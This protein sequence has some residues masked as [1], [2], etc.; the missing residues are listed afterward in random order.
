MAIPTIMPRC[1]GWSFATNLAAIGAAITP[2]SA[3]PPTVDQSSSILLKFTKKPKLAA[4]ATQNSEALTVPITFLGSVEVV[5]MIVGVTTG[6]Q[7]PPPD[8]SMKPPEKPR[9]LKNFGL[10]TSIK[11]GGF[12]DLNIFLYRSTKPSIKRI[13]DMKTLEFDKSI[14]ERKFAPIK[15]PIEPGIA[16]LIMI[17][18]STFSACQCDNP[19]A[20]VVPI[21]AKCTAAD[22]TAAVA[23]AVTKRVEL[24]IPNPIPSAPSINCAIAPTTANTI[25]FTELT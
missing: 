10:F 22:A 4:K 6:P 13:V 5:E 12:S 2:P 15:A 25:Q 8:A 11:L 21:S 3:S 23:P 20:K 1:F 14:L 19:D 24:V 7:P 9:K 18:L 17:F 16:S